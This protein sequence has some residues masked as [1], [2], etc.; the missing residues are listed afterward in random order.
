MS[1]EPE[2]EF[3]STIHHALRTWRRRQTIRI[4][5]T[6]PDPVISVREVA[7]ELTASEQGTEPVHAT[8]EPYRNVYNALVQTHLPTL[9]DAGIIVY[10]SERQTVSRGQNFT[11]ASLVLEVEKPIFRRLHPSND[12]DS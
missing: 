7:K 10:D 4:I 3:L 6:R 1:D 5:G 9:S 11:I 12:V 8:G 2:E